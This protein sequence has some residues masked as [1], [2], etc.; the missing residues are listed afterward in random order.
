MIT[1]PKGNTFDLL[2]PL[3]QKN[4]DG[5]VSVLDTSTMTDISVTLIRNGVSYAKTHEVSEQGL[6][7]SFPASMKTGIYSVI[8]KAMIGEKSIQSNI[9]NAFQ[10]AEWNEEANWQNHI[11]SGTFSAEPSLFIAAPAEPEPEPEP[12]PQDEVIDTF[13]T[14]DIDGTGGFDGSLNGNST[15]TQLADFPEWR[16]HAQVS[17]SYIYKGSGC[18][19]FGNASNKG[20]LC[21]GI[22]QRKA[23]QGIY[24]LKFKAVKWQGSNG[25]LHCIVSICEDMQ[26]KHTEFVLTTT[27]FVQQYGFIIDFKEVLNDPTSEL[28]IEILLESS[29]IG[30]RC[31]VGDIELVKLAES[32]DE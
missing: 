19:R 28:Q 24:L 21:I 30:D 27:E 14:A 7:V 2:F 8:I 10:I 16:G 22:D 12:E 26:I 13:S 9:R 20:V 6:L 3:V 17:N 4:H 1:I 5:S 25:K 23:K 18:I 31:F 11:T 32:E 29:T 15:A